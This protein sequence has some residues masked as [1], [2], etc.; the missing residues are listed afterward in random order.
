MRAVIYAGCWYIFI[1]DVGIYCLYWYLC[2]TLVFVSVLMYK[3]IWVSIKTRLTLAL[4]H[5]CDIALNWY[6]TLYIV[7]YAILNVHTQMQLTGWHQLYDLLHN[8]AH[9]KNKNITNHYHKSFLSSNYP[10]S[11]VFLNITQ[12]YMYWLLWLIVTITTWHW[13]KCYISVSVYHD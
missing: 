8:Y 13:Y 12:Y 7:W 5:K 6:H 1:H 2:L 3:T 9:C 11:T 4:T 10:Q